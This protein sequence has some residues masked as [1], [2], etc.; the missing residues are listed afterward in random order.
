MND[1]EKAGQRR[2][3]GAAGCKGACNWWAMFL[4]QSLLN[5]CFHSEGVGEGGTTGLLLLQQAIFC[6]CKATTSIQP[7]LCLS[8]CEVHQACCL[9]RTPAAV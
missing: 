1:Y 7:M 2:V 8:C 9:L 5:C 6:N 4:S 3:A